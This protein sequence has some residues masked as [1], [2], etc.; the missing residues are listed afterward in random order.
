MQPHIGEN[1]VTWDSRGCLQ[2]PNDACRT[3][4]FRAC[5]LNVWVLVCMT[6]GEGEVQRG[7]R[8]WQADCEGGRQQRLG[9]VTL[10]QLLCAV[11]SPQFCLT[12]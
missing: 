11:T 6:A 9:L 7:L 3:S 10:S 4:T 5:H 12:P 1:L 2:E 8:G